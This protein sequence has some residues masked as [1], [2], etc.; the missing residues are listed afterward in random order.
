MLNKKQ[1]LEKAARDLEKTL[2]K[3]GFNK[4]KKTN[5]KIIIDRFPNLN[6]RKDYVSGKGIAAIPKKSSAAEHPDAKQ[7][8]VGFN[9]KQG[10]QLIT[11]ADDLSYMGGKKT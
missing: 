4:I 1:R 7:F 8:P 5:K 10:L 2:E 11:G 9:H 3:T 6:T